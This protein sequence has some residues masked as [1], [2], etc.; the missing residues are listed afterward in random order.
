MKTSQKI[1]FVV[2]GML[3]LSAHVAAGYSNFLQQ[4]FEI[5]VSSVT[6][7]SGKTFQLVTDEWLQEGKI[8]VGSENRTAFVK[9]DFQN[10]ATILTGFDCQNCSIK[11]YSS[12]RSDTKKDPVN[13]DT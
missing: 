13:K 10:E 2:A 11:T 9:L 8:I 4:H 12:T 5:G 6:P 1:F 7:S 3:S